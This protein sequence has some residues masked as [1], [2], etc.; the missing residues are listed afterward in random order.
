MLKIA[1]ISSY[2]SNRLL[3]KCVF[4][5]VF[6]ALLKVLAVSTKYYFSFK[7]LYLVKQEN[8]HQIGSVAT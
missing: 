8:M 6:L 5:K 4:R 2:E 7:G 1:C 3:A